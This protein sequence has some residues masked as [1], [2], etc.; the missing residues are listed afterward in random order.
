[1]TIAPT[2]WCS[3]TRLNFRL[4]SVWC[5]DGLWSIADIYYCPPDCET[6]GTYHRLGYRAGGELCA[7]NESH[8]RP[9]APGGWCTNEIQT[10]ERGFKARTELRVPVDATHRCQQGA[11]QE[12]VLRHVYAV[13]CCYED[14]MDA[15]LRSV[16]ERETHSRAGSGGW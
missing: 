16:T 11:R 10:Q 12:T 4:H 6:A 5:C 1:M 15:P 2:A 14:V 13:S 7:R 3:T 9:E 8:Q